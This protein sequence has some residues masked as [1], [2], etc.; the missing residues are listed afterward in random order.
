MDDADTRSNA[1]FV[2]G[3]LQKLHAAACPMEIRRELSET[4][5]EVLSVATELWRTTAAK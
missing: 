2:Y 4:N 3:D 5:Y 1:R